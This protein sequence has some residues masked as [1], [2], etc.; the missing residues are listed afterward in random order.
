MLENDIVYCEPIIKWTSIVGE[1]GHVTFGDRERDAVL[2]VTPAPEG[3]RIKGD[4]VSVGRYLPV[5]YIVERVA[6]A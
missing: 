6:S 4:D 3:S 2:P 5:P 1:L